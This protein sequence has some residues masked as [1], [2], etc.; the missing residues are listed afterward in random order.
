MSINATRTRARVDACHVSGEVIFRECASGFRHSEGAK[1][2][3][4]KVS[5]L[6]IKDYLENGTRSVRNG[7]DYMFG[8]AVISAP[9]VSVRSISF[10]HETPAQI[11]RANSTLALPRTRWYGTSCGLPLY[12]GSEFSKLVKDCA[13]GA[14]KNWKECSMDK[15]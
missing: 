1:N 9:D 4:N 3:G 15:T 12:R 7:S 13:V 5:V 11:N 8:T 10:V 6:A 14:P 2:V